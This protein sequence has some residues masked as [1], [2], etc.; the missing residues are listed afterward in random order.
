MAEPVDFAASSRAVAERLVAGRARIDTTI[1]EG[2]QMYRGDL[3]SYLSVC[4]SALAQIGHAMAICGRTSPARVL[5]FACGHGRVL[6]GL[7]ATFPEAELTGADVN[8]DGVDFCA[9][10]FGSLPVYSDPDP[11]KVSLAG[12]Y[13]LV[14]VGS[15]FTHLDAGRCREFLDLLRRNLAPGGLLVFSTH[16]RNAVDRWPLDDERNRAIVEGFQRDGFGYRDHPGV[17]GYGTT[18]FTAAWI[19][20]Q[21]APWTDL[22]LVGYVERGLADHQDVV[23]VL[24]TDVHHPQDELLVV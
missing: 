15:L 8:R 6:R 5:D 1:G 2:D 17:E 13:D 12:D 7:R 19:A 18:A 10:Q 16:G 4:H 3:D 23:A 11:A 14:W 9:R 21:L 22:M 20:E 24:K